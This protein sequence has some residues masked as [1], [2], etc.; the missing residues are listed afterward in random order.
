[1]A[2]AGAEGDER[3]QVVDAYD[4]L[5]FEFAFEVSAG[6]EFDSVVKGLLGHAVGDGS[7]GEGVG[8]RGS[9]RTKLLKKEVDVRTVAAFTE[10]VVHVDFIE[11]GDFWV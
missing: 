7:E 3:V 9:F 8:F 6:V 2:A 1:M 10:K 11:A 4:G 5:G